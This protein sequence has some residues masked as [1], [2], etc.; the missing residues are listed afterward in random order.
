LGTLA[1]PGDP[2]SAWT[3]Y[4]RSLLAPSRA[5]GPALR[6]TVDLGDVYHSRIDLA[7]GQSGYPGSPHY[8]DALR[9]WLSGDPRFL[10]THPSDIEDRAIGVWEIRPRAGTGPPASSAAGAS[11]E[12]EGSTAAGAERTAP[13]S[14]SAEGA[15]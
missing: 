2:D 3:I 7:G 12:T 6:Y 14:P 1:P 9:D 8:G 13:E 11:A 10:W 15:P 4:H 5:V